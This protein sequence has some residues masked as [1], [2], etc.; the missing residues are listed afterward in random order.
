MLQ[1]K[2]IFFQPISLQGD[3]NTEGDRLMVAKGGPGGTIRSAF[4]SSKG[5][6]KHIRLDL[7]LIA[8]LGLVG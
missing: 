1:L 5:Q 3:L 2:L 7:K 6:T 8:D 4:E